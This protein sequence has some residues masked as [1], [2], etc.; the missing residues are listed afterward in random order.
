MG[1]QKK[2]F[3]EQ[4]ICQTLL[5][6]ELYAFIVA[7]SDSRI[8][9]WNAGAE[10]LFG[11]PREHVLGQNLHELI[12]PEDVQDRAIDAF[13][14]FSETGTGP[15]I[16]SVIE[17]D[18]LHRDGSL[19]PVELAL[20]A[21]CIDGVWFSQAVVRGVGRRKEVEAE[22]KRL[23][24]TDPLTGVFNRENLFDHGRRE[25]SRAIRYGHNLSLV[26]FE[27]DQLKEINEEFGHYAGDKVIQC[28]SDFLKENCRQSDI[29]GRFSSKEVLL[30][31]PETGVKPTAVV[32]EKWRVA[33][34]KLQVNVDNN[35]IS[36][37][38]SLGVSALENEE[39][40]STVLNKAEA[41]LQ[42]AKASGGNI[43]VC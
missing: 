23:A 4:G 32:A 16:D 19:F 15:F 36:F 3:L 9:F 21:N 33:V 18:A 6:S 14:H 5:A 39:K 17:I 1:K 22:M 7:D 42:E 31:L 37:H 38:C 24:T 13:N 26:L 28:L 35:V 27:I 30:L 43:V 20:S 41:N 34:E 11:H 8:V 25:L 29:I 10:V 40:F 12:A 2:Q